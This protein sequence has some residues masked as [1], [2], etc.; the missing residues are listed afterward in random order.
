MKLWDL[1]VLTIAIWTKIIHNSHLIFCTDLL[2][3]IAKEIPSEMG[4]DINYLG[5]AILES[6]K[7]LFGNLHC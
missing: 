4:A 6:L 3:W 1:K 2:A 5:L 7:L